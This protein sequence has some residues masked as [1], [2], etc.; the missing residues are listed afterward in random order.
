MK[1]CVIQKFCEAEWGWV[2]RSPKSIGGFIQIHVS[3][4]TG[5]VLWHFLGVIRH[6]K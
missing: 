2:S 3:Y 5:A 4:K 6:S 1:L